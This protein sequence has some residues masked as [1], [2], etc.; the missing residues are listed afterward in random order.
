MDQKHMRAGLR[1][2]DVKRWNMV[3]TIR[4]QSTL[5]HSAS[6][7]FIAAR[8]A[9]ILGKDPMQ[10][11]YWAMMH[12]I[13]EDTTGDMPSHVKAE[14]RRRG[15]EVNDM[16]KF[17]RVPA[18]F[19]TVVKMADRLEGIFWL[20]EYRHGSHANWVLSDI[21]QSAAKFLEQL[22]DR[23]VAAYRAVWAELNDD[24]KP[25]FSFGSDK[26]ALRGHLSFYA[27][28]NERSKAA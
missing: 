23:H 1:L 5:E 12:D 20:S 9:D 6:V 26:E 13:D 11:M 15:V 24:I 19:R 17:D 25:D 22:D 21:E 28:G 16:A 3:R 18:E 10:A 2:A 14:I 7:G 27:S 4:D 8:L